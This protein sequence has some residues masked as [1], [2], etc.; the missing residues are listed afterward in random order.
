MTRTTTRLALQA[1]HPDAGSAGRIGIMSGIART[2]LIFTATPPATIIRCPP[3][4]G[5]GT[6]ADGRWYARH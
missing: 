3:T 2:A 5:M 6:E 4:E 1:A